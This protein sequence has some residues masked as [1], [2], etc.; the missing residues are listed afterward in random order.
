[1][2]GRLRPLN[3]KY[4][5]VAELHV[6]EGKPITIAC[7]EVG[8]AAKSWYHN[9]DRDDLKA[10][11][12]ELEAI[13]VEKRATSEYSPEL[14]LEQ[15]LRNIKQG[16]AGGDLRTTELVIRNI[17]KLKDIGKKEVDVGTIMTLMQE[18]GLGLDNIKEPDQ[19]E[20]S[21]DQG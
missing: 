6:L 18:A 16:L 2:P 7:R 1:M 15:A 12:K 19:D 21:G 5:K 9:R 13:K 17:D 14:L 3:E 4:R 20:I 8:M 10:Y 11:I